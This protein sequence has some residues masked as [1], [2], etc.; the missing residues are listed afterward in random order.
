MSNF[1]LPEQIAGEWIWLKKNANKGENHIFFRRDFSI[2]ELPASAEMWISA[3]SSFHLYIN[4]RH[5]C[6]GPSASADGVV[7][8]SYIDVTYLLNPGV[9][10]ISLLV[11]NANYAMGNQKKQLGGLWAQLNLNDQPYLWTDEKWR[12]MNVNGYLPSAISQYF[13]GPDVEI[14]D[15]RQIHHN[16]KNYAFPPYKRGFVTTLPNDNMAIKTGKH[17]WFTPDQ[18]TSLDDCNLKLVAGQDMKT[19]IS[20]QAYN[21]IVG[22]GRFGTTRQLLW[23]NFR[24]IAS[25]S[26]GGVFIAQTFLYADNEGDVNFECYCNRP[27]RLFLNNDLVSEQAPQPPPVRLELSSRGNRRLSYAEYS[28]TGIT[29]HMK[30]GWNHLFFIEDCDSYGH[31]ITIYS[32]D[33]PTSAI[34]AHCSPMAD[35]PAGWTIAGPMKSPFTLILPILQIPTQGLSEFLLGDNYPWDASIAHQAMEF[36]PENQIL[37]NAGS[38]L[39]REH[40]YQIYDFG[41]TIYGYPHLIIKGSAGDIVEIVCGNII[42]DN[43]VVSFERGHRLTT[44]LILSGSDDEWLPCSPMGFRYVMVMARR[45]NSGV[46]VDSLFA[47]TFTTEHDNAGSLITSD[48]TWNKIWKTGDNTLK[49][50]MRGG[51][52]DSPTGEQCQYIPDAMMQSWAAYH[53]YG[54]YD[55]VEDSI[56]AF[57]RAQFETGNMNALAPSAYFHAIPDFA[58][59]WII[60]V[61]RHFMYTGSLM[62]L[63]EMFE[64]IE[65]LLNFFNC[66]AIMD[67]G[68]LDDM[69]D[70]H[71]CLPQIDQ[72][73]DI[74]L[75]GISTSLNAIYVKALQCATEIADCC[76]KLDQRE[77]WQNRAVNVAASVRRLNLR[78]DGSFA[79]SYDT[80][81][82]SC[83]DKA[84]WQSDLLAVYGGFTTDEEAEAIWNRLFS[85]EEPFLKFDAGIL[86]SPYFKYFVLETACE[87]GK[88]DWAMRYI[89]YYWGN[90]VE[91]GATT[92]WE[93][94]SP[95]KKTEELPVCSKCHGYGVLPNAYIIPTLCGLIPTYCGFT[96]AIFSPNFHEVKSLQLL[97]PLPNGKISIQWNTDSNGEIQVNIS[98]TFPIELQVQISEE[99]AQL[100]TFTPNH[101]VSFVE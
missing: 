26:K 27:Y 21:D 88:L 86:E 94:Y 1:N 66:V 30:Q 37:D 97:L 58:L 77:V 78:P 59:L 53:L 8:A 38:A 19:G 40:Q 80:A 89:K 29:V 31:G 79:D 93:F 60:W 73:G 42:A 81:S 28:P 100:V 64:R 3:G 46:T 10:Q 41:R 47:D 18:I 61:H 69:Q 76:G 96:Q 68:P 17:T 34:S 20:S 23:V 62:F 83:S 11:F 90:M 82:E 99:D 50:T 85:D 15:Y 92:W 9:N 63:N 16:W 32:P 43:A 12:C 6:A 72:D 57:A 91:A 65:N 36:M 84:S 95:T 70:Y 35:S 7:N 13:G 25:K 55:Y 24:E 44:S 67:N 39:L 5:C 51:F 48:S 52:I 71:G 54:E 4:G 101:N 33:C 87:L 14:I 45:I 22:R 98:S 2:D 75:H 74:E 49:N 56:R